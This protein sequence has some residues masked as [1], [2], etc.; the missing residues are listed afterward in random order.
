VAW[1]LILPLLLLAAGCL[2]DC[3]PTQGDTRPNLILVTVDTLRADHVG[4]YGNT[5]VRTPHLDR[6]ANE[7]V[8][9]ERAFSQSHITVPSH[10]SILTSLP[11]TEHGVGNNQAPVARPV[12]TL[13]ALLREAGYRT[14]GFVGASHLGPRR[15]LGQLV[16]PGLEVFDF[17]QRASKPR[18]AEDTNAKFF[19]WLNR[20]CGGPFFAWIHYWDPHMP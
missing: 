17:P 19:R 6:L 4:A 18:R 7:G 13:P 10:L 2:P 15:A 20:S 1:R 16:A 11:V 12:V 8:V 5:R 9:F 3:T 14:A